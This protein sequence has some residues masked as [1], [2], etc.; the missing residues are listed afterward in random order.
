MYHH[1]P[2]SNSSK[3]IKIFTKFPRE[4]ISDV[5]KQDDLT[6]DELEVKDWITIR[7]LQ[8]P[9]TKDI[10][11]SV[12]HYISKCSY[13]DASQDTFSRNLS[14]WI[15]KVERRIGH[16]RTILVG[17][18]N[19]SP[20]Q[21]GIIKADG[22]NGTMSQRIARRKWQQIRRDGN[23]YPFFYNPMWNLLGDVN[24]ETPGTFYYY[25]KEP[26]NLF[27]YMLD[28]VLIRPDLLDNFNAHELKILT[29]DGVSSFLS[30]DGI[31]DDKVASDHLPLLFKLDL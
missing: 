13:I 19:M 15:K 16:S 3:R 1:A 10:L 12:I 22:L 5:S 8:F 4:F 24:S 2:N 18:L 25:N 31:P 20:F 11:L 14:D 26:V 23:K 17:D 9:G 21:N 7:H 6:Q 30:E 29:S 28:Q 27:W